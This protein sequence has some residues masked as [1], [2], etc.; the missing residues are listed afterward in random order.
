MIKKLLALLFF[1]PSIALASSFVEGKDYQTLTNPSPKSDKTPSVTEFFSYGCPSCYKLQTP[2]SEW[3]T[4]KG[5]AIKFEQVPVVFKPTWALYAKAF[6]TTKL[7]AMSE[8]MNPVLFKAIQDEKANYDTPQAMVALF[9]SNGIDADVAK[10]A[11][12]NS[13]SI[14]LHL[15]QANDLMM[16]YQIDSVPTLVVN[17]K[18]KTSVAMAG[19]PERLFEVLDY[20]IRK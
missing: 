18:Y 10:S 1:I 16:Q 4:K 7:L 19:S 12:E 9:V 8:K 5:N 14:D 6:Y 2:L 15:N 3:V 11:F 17:N 13:P 20:L